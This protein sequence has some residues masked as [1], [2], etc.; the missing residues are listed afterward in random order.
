MHAFNIGKLKKKLEISIFCFC[1]DGKIKKI[2]KKEQS[3]NIFGR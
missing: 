3:V 1:V 2:I